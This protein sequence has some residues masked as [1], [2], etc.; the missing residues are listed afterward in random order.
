M[1]NQ[2]EQLIRAERVRELAENISTK[3]FVQKYSYGITILESMITGYGRKCDQRL[4]RSIV[5][6]VVYRLKTAE[7]IADKLEKK[8]YEISLTNAVEQ[9]SDLAGIRVICSFCD[10][11]YRMDEFLQQRNDIAICRRKDYIRNPKESGYRSIH[12]IVEMD[13][14]LGAAGEKVRLEVQIRTVA[15]NYWAK[16]D[17]QLCYKT[18]GR[19]SGQS[20]EQIR[21]ELRTYAEEISGIDEKML[22]LRKRI[23]EI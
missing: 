6:T 7:S 15:M 12:L 4:G 14:P 3:Q 17:H 16:L 5:D 13:Y 9:L 23:E 22:N 10:D 18:G 20:I 1:G 11:V 19:R 2:R 21:R 8:G